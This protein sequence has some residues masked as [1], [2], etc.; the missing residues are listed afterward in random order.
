MATGYADV[1]RIH[2]FVGKEQGR[3]S[4]V[5]KKLNL[6]RE[7]VKS[8][9]VRS[10]VRTGDNASMPSFMRSDGTTGDAQSS[11]HPLSKV[12]SSSN[13]VAQSQSKP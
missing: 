11:Y 8:L 12:T 13:T 6:S 5:I 2:C 1:A 10:A 7:T 4:K 9:N 3:M